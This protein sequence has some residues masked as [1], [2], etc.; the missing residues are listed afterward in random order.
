MAIFPGDN[1]L[2]A[3]YFHYIFICDCFRFVCFVYGKNNL[4]ENEVCKCSHKF[5]NVWLTKNCSQER[6]QKKERWSCAKKPFT[7]VNESLCIFLRPLRHHLLSR[8]N[9]TQK[10]QDVKKTSF[11][12]CNDVVITSKRRHFNIHVFAGG[13]RNKKYGDQESN[14]EIPASKS[15]I[16]QNEK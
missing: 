11:G 10:A 14:F 5:Q 2:F 6:V 15:L 8:Y 4:N 16:T 1:G 13:K 7:C 12:R 9:T 3:T